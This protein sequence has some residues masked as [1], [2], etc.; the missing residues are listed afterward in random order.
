MTDNQKMQIIINEV[1]NH[2]Q[3]TDKQL[4]TESHKRQ[5]TEPRFT[6]FYFARQHTKLSHAA[7]GM[8]YG[9]DHSSVIHGVRLIKGLIKYNGFGEKTTVIADG[10][11]EQLEPNNKP[12]RCETCGQII[13]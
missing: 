1:C 5:F 3:V 7:I 12:V 11:N 8:Y 4:K 10:I 6:I 2:F 9:R 13:L